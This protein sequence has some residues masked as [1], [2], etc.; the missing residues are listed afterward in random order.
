MC[1]EFVDC[2]C[3]TIC[4]CVAMPSLLSDRTRPDLIPEDQQK[5]FAQEIQNIQVQ[6]V[7]RQLE[8]F[9]CVDPPSYLDTCLLTLT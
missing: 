8:D 3:V 2:V 6:E 9:R 1:V 5:R 4:T 7:L